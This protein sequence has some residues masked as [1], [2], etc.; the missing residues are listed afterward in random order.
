MYDEGG[1]DF[2]D[3]APRRSRPLENIRTK[4]VWWSIGVM[5]LVAAE[6]QGEGSLLKLAYILTF[7]MSKRSWG[8]HEHKKDPSEG[9]QEQMDTQGGLAPIAIVLVYIPETRIPQPRRK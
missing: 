8:T 7:K 5:L 9:V 1:I 6:M 3:F 2:G 4:V